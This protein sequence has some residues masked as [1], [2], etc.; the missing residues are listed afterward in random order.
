MYMNG[1]FCS[2]DMIGELINS[3]YNK[4]LQDE[5]PIRVNFRKILSNLNSSER[6]SHLIHSY[7]AKLLH[8][9]PYFFLFGAGIIPSFT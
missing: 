7:P 5:T 4:Y 3:F 6:Y 8:H 2:D 9:I 1:P